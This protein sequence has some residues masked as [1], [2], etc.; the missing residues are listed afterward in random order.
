MVKQGQPKPEKASSSLNI[1]ISPTGHWHF[2]KS[3]R[4][5]FTITDAKSNPISG[6]K[7]TVTVK[8]RLGSTDVLKDM[9]DNGDGTYSRE[10][11]ALDI[12]S[13]YS[14]D[15]SIGIAF[16][17]QGSNYFNHWSAEVVRDGNERI[18]PTVGGV[19]Y[20]YLVRYAWDP[21]RVKAGQEVI[22]Y[23][24]NRR[25]IQTGDK[26]NTEQPSR[27]ACDYLIDL[28]NVSVLVETVAGSPVATLTPTYT[29]IGIYRAKYTPASAGE[30]KVS[31]LFTDPFNGY[32]LDKAK[33]SYPLVVGK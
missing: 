3:K 4:L 27:N 6:L 2:N 21:G 10:Y 24:D 25:A 5:T 7:P 16:S 17:Y 29:G 12:G 23:F 18:M 26:L 28:K 13:N 1:E 31:F 19:L 9:I 30:Y 15:Y 33:T 8:T 20:S 14:M 11:T 22:M 32:T